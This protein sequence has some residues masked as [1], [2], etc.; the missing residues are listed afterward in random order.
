MAVGLFNRGRREAEVSVESGDIGLSG[1]QPVRDLW[2]RK[3]IGTFEGT[4]TASVPG[5]GAVMLK[6]GTPASES[7]PAKTTE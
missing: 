7:P 5:H 4:Y 6:I 1:P 2:V 3:D